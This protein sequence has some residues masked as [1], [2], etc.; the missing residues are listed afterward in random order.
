MLYPSAWSLLAC[1]VACVGFKTAL[2]NGEV[3]AS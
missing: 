2:H 1:C 3:V